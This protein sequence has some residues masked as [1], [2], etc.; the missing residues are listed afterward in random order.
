MGM[1]VILN[2]ALTVPSSVVVNL[3][4]TLYSSELLSI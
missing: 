2:G 1:M 3:L 4:F